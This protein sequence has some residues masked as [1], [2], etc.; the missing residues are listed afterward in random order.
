M[1]KACKHLRVRR[2]N[3]LGSKCFTYLDDCKSCKCLECNKIVVD[4]TG[5]DIRKLFEKKYITYKRS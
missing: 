4:C 3:L 2:L 5:N 1:K